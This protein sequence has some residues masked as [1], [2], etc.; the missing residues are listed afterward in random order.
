MASETWVTTG[1]SA[2]FRDGNRATRVGLAWPLAAALAAFFASAEMS[3]PPAV[4]HT[5]RHSF[6]VHAARGHRH[7]LLD[8]DLL[9][10][11]TAESASRYTRLMVAAKVW[12]LQS[13]RL[14]AFTAA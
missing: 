3:P 5:S 11:T 8:L 1:F 10:L 14:S 12:F 13:Y 9:V 7:V 4:L 6:H 2:P